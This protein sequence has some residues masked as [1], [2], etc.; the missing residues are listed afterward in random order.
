MEMKTAHAFTLIELLV[1]IVIIAILMGLAFPAFQAVQNQARKTQAKNDLMQIVTAVNAF[2]TEYGKYPVTGATDVKLGGGTASTS[3]ALFTALRGLDLTLNPRQIVFISP[4][5]VKDKANPRSGIATQTTAVNGVSVTSGE[6]VDPW[7]TPYAVEIDADY[8]N[9]V[10]TNPYTADTGAGPA[11]IR[12][13]VVAWSL[14]KDQKGGSGSK[15]SPDSNDD[16]IS[17]Q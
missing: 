9:Q 12:Q 14:G 8:T 6:L 2:Y 1:V 10:E 4:P 13:G 5:D 7:G 11:Q 3:A 17:W 15:T 16:I